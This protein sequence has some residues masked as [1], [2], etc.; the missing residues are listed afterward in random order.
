[1]GNNHPSTSGKPNHMRPHV[2]KY[3]VV[4]CVIQFLGEGS[5]DSYTSAA[6]AENYDILR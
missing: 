5:S 2:D 3:E 4:L 6:T 1:M